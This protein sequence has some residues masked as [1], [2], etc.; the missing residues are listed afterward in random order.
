MRRV[1]LFYFLLSVVTVFWGCSSDDEGSTSVN[2]LWQTSLVASK[3]G[4]DIETVEEDN[5]NNEE[6]TRS[7]FIGGQTGTRFVKLWD[8]YDVAQVYKNGVQV[9]SLTP[10]SIGNLYS[11][12]TGTLEGSYAIGDELTL[13]MPSPDLDYTGQ[14]GTIGNMSRYFDFMT[15]TVKVAS[16]E[17]STVT[18][19]DLSFQSCQGY[20]KLVFRDENNLKLH[21]KQVVVH[22]ANG[23]LVASKSLDGTTVHTE[24]LIVN[25][26]MESSTKDYPS[27]IYLALLNDEDKKVAYSFTV[28]AT[29]GK[30]YKSKT[31]LSATFKA[32]GSL[33]TSVRATTCSTVDM[34][35]QTAITPPESDEPDV[36]QVTL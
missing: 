33:T 2:R 3:L 23:K 8:Q 17:G 11:T 35:V 30:T 18:T 19:E 12:L 34:E 22:A 24:D 26:V 29:D 31:T 7:L 4:G 28:L 14:D 16:V 32:G 1:N 15:A 25:T 6:L 5:D 9:G 27:D 13:Y 21:V 20:L 36:Q 10:T